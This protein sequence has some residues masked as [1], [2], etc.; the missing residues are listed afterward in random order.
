M[1]S[2]RGDIERP[3]RSPDLSPSDYFLWSYVK[4]DVYKHRPTTI[5]GLKAAIRQTVNEI[6]QE[7]IR[8]VMEV[9]ESLTAV[10]LSSRASP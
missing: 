2:S 8:G 9:L 3:A 1:I 7:I 6:I 4:A 5:N 10:Y